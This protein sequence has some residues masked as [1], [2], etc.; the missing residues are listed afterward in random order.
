[1]IAKS[2]GKF[3][4]KGY[5]LISLRTMQNLKKKM[6]TIREFTEEFYKVNIRSSH[7]EDTPKTVSRYVNRLRFDI[8]DE[9]SLM[10]LIYVEEAYQ[11]AF[12]AEDK[13]MRKHSQRTRVK[14][15]RGK[16]QQQ[17][18]GEASAIQVSKHR[19][20]NLMITKEEY[21]LQEDEE[22]EKVDR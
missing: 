20:I 21:F 19:L 8:Q 4:P 14:G 22:E 16:E 9:L 3:L 10:S 7:I 15:S 2:K 1:M 18:K 13:L 17:Q 5:Q 11:V 12:K 6:M